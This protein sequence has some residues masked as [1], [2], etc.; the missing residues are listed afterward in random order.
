MKNYSQISK[1]KFAQGSLSLYLY[2]NQGYICLNNYPD[3][4]IYRFTGN[5]YQLFKKL[6]I[7]KKLA[8]KSF[9]TFTGIL[10]MPRDILKITNNK[11]I[12]R[13]GVP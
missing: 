7:S 13:H 5:E 11:T 2:N 12:I 1:Y 4:R 8:I 3:L 9:F 10:E 6:T